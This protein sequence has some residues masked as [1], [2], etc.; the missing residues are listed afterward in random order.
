MGKPIGDLSSSQ[1]RELASRDRA[2]AWRLTKF[3]VIWVIV[4]FFTFIPL[5]MPFKG[6]PMVA[7]YFGVPVVSFVV[8]VIYQKQA[9]YYEK[10]AAV[11]SN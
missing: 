8:A 11:Q 10:L 7:I 5:P 3:S 6:W 2:I 1:L 4:V 9:A